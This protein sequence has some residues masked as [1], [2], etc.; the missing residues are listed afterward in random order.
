MITGDW[1]FRLSDDETLANIACSYNVSGS[2]I[3]GLKA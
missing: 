1:V 2:M 3:S